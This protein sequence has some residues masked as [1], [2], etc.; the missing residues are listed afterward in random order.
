M[1]KK[2]LVNRFV[3]YTSRKDFPLF[4]IDLLF[5]KQPHVEQLGHVFVWKLHTLNR[6]SFDVDTILVSCDRFYRR[7]LH[8]DDFYV[9]PHMVDMILD[10]TQGLD[11]ILQN[12]S[13][14]AERE[15][16]KVKKQNFSYEITS[17]GEKVSMFYHD[18]YEPMVENRFGKTDMFIP[19][20]AGCESI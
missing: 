12:V 18:M 13:M 3:F 4:L 2:I 8:L 16:K 14:D 10:C 20:G 15:I 19:A 7:F 5:R 1:L 9:F 17:D 11:R 6:F